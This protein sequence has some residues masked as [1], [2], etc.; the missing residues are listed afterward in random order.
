MKLNV[1]L[2]FPGTCKEA[3][4]FYQ[5]ILG[6]EITEEHPYKGSPIEEMVSD[7]WLDKTMHATLRTGNIDLMGSDQGPDRFQP[8]QGCHI[9]VRL[10]SVGEAERIFGA[11]ADGGEIEMPLEK[12]FWAERFGMLTDRFGVNW[13]VNCDA[14][15]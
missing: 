7:D 8:V 6:G 2:N 9:S 15:G 13:M 10:D 12:T 4:A 5:K 14:A 3:L 1:Y 11:L